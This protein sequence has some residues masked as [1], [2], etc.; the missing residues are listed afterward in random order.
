MFICMYIILFFVDFK[1]TLVNNMDKEEIKNCVR[2]FAQCGYFQ[3]SRHCR[4]RMAER[5]ITVDD[6][7]NV[8]MWGEVTEIEH[9][10]EHGNWSC[11]IKGKDIEGEA[12][13]FVAGVSKDCYAVRC[14]T[15]Y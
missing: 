10:A 12:L 2:E 9:K 15:V 7:L 6:V 13:V 14:I 5:S 1:S 4:E 8:L 3:M 11:R